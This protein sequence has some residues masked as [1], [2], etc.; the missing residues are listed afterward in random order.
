[1][2]AEIVDAIQSGYAVGMIAVAIA[3]V[4]LTRGI[5]YVFCEP[6]VKLYKRR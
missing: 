6:K 5:R 4:C 3:I 2:N 1:M